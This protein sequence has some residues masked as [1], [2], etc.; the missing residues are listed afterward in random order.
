MERYLMVFLGGAFGSLARYLVAG[1]MVARFGSALPLATFAVNITGSFLIGYLAMTFA[2]RHDLWR[3]A[4]MTGFL[5]GYTTFS[6]LELEIF[7]ALKFGD[8]RVALLYPLLSVIAGLL[9]VAAGAALGSPR[10]IP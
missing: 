4:L 3:L 9:A 5:G 7:V 2:G 1:A 6:A 8:L 10:L